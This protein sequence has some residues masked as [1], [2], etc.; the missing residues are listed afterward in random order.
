MSTGSNN[1][2]TC[3]KL[4][5]YH[6]P[7]WTI[8]IKF[9]VKNRSSQKHVTSEELNK[10]WTFTFCKFVSVFYY[11]L[12]INIPCF[13][14]SQTLVNCQNQT[15]KSN[16]QYFSLKKIVDKFMWINSNTLWGGTS[17]NNCEKICFRFINCNNYVHY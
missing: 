17:G 5:R 4:Y 10:S 16:N 14:A 8:F 12:M 2:P 6:F 3:A 11:S 1:N 9:T 7:S 13:L 15:K